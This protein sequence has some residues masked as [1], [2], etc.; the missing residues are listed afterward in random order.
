MIA[1]EDCSI[2]T[3]TFSEQGKTT[4]LAREKDFLRRSGNSGED[5]E[6]SVGK[7]V[8]AI[9]G[10]GRGLGTRKR[11]WKDSVGFAISC[12]TGTRT[13]W[14]ESN[15]GEESALD[16]VRTGNVVGGGGGGGSAARES[17]EEGSPVGKV[18]EARRLAVEGGGDDRSGQEGRG[19]GRRGRSEGGGP[20]APRRGR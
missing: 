15:G 4:I 19:G 7:S 20:A 16:S 9:R 17:D 8:A 10:E 6:K 3:W 13:L 5:S 18:E 12:R 14:V 1:R 2:E 11:R